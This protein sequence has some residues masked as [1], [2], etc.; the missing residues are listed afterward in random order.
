MNKKIGGPARIIVLFVV[1][2]FILIY[3]VIAHYDSTTRRSEPGIIGN[4]PGNLYAY[5]LFCDGGDRIYYS[6]YKD[7]GI[8]Y[9]MSFDLTDHQIV[10]GDVAKYINCDDHYLYYSR[11]NNLKTPETRPVFKYYS[12]GIY[13]IGKNGRNFKS[14]W[15][16]P[17]GSVLYYD[18][19]IY[20]LYYAAGEKLVMHR[21]NIDGKKDTVLKSEES[22]AVCMYDNNL[23]YAGLEKDRSLYS[24]NL[25][26]GKSSVAVEGS[27]YEPIVTSNGI[28]YIDPMKG[29]TLKRCDLDGSNAE[30]L[31]DER[32]GSFNITP[33][34]RYLY[35]QIDNNSDD[36]GLYRTDLAT[37]EILMIMAGDYKFINLVGDYC[38]FY[39]TDESKVMCYKSGQGSFVFDPPVLSK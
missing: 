32:I 36:N 11:M 9:S 8:L 38:F 37:G 19:M 3:A 12:N 26:S 6:N 28:Y 22:P 14:L 34:N 18:G 33:D 15:N 27:F 23:Y 25:D 20:Y 17:V 1:G 13:R 29:Y 10:Y 21:M 16:K 7:Q 30:V 4:T 2:G 35:Y 24:I 39:T 31:V 5:G